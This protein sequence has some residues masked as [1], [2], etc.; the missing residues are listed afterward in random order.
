MGNTTLPLRIARSADVGSYFD[1]AID[2]VA[3][4]NGAPSS[5]QVQDHY[6]P[7]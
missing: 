7:R 4:Y 5:A 6:N 2:E 3:I 1:G